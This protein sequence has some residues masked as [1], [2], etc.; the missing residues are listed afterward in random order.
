MENYKILRIIIAMFI[1][2]IVGLSVTQGM[3]I[4]AILSIVIGA[5]ISCIY[6]KNIDV[7][8]EDE[9][10]IKINGKASRMA[11]VLFSITLA[12]IGLILITMRN[13]Y[14]DFIQLGYTLSYSAIA[15]LALYYI[16]YRYYHKKYGY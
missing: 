5:M 7:T 4:P 11:M 14:P 12:I 1:G 10:T 2:I 9:I 8:L 3:I 13:E 6:K 15:I 16:F